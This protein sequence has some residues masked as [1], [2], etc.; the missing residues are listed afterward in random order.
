LRGSE[1][2]SDFERMAEVGPPGMVHTRTPGSD[3]TDR[4]MAM[5][6]TWRAENHELA[7]LTRCGEKMM[8]DRS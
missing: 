4:R 6:I 2:K 8:T 1:R 5:T 3:A 7:R